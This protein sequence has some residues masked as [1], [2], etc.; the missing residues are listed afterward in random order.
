MAEIA[1]FLEDDLLRSARAGQH[2]FIGLM[3]KVLTAAGNKVAFLPEADAHGEV[4]AHSLVHMGPPL[5]RHGLTFRRVYHYP[6]WRIETTERRWAWD[7]AR[8]RFDPEAVPSDTAARFRA[9]WRKRL[10][11]VTE[12]PPRDPG[13]H[14]YIPLQGRLTQHRSFQS[15][16][17]IEMIETVMRLDPGRKVIATLHP[18][19]VHDRAERAALEGLLA[20]HPALSLD[21]RPPLQ[22]LAECAHVVTQNSSVA[23][24]GFFFD[25]PAILFARID[26]HHIALSVPEIGPDRA[27][28]QVGTHRPDYARYLYWFWQQ[29]SINAGRDD[30]ASQIARRFRALGWPV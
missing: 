17:P 25:R 27:F 5:G 29:Q 28:G 14:V 13:G 12:V 21:D 4:P 3:H 30:A 18:K 1:I 10:F 26:F 24:N 15:M 8:A 22:H 20:R 9:Q 16:S 23:F 19:E 11:S 2:N 7:V 6:F